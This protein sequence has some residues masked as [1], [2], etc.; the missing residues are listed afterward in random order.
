MKLLKKISAFVLG[1]VLCVV[2]ASCGGK[3][4]PKSIDE[5]ATYV[6]QMYI[7]KAETAASFEVVDQVRVG[8]EIFS[9]SWSREITS[10]EEA[11]VTIG[12]A[13][14]HKV[15][16]TI[17]INKVNPVKTEYKVTAKIENA[18]KSESKDVEFNWF[19]PKYNKNT[20]A[21][22][23]AAQKDDP[24]M[25]SGIVTATT[26][27]STTYKNVGVWLQD[28]EGGYYAYQL[29]CESEEKFLAEL[30]PGCA[31]EVTGKA[32]PYNGWKEMASKCTYE[33]ISSGNPIP[34]FKDITEDLKTKSNSELEVYQ[35]SKTS[36]TG[37]VSRLYDADKYGMAGFYVKVDADSE[38]LI[39]LKHTEKGPLNGGAAAHD[40]IMNKVTVGATVTVKGIMV[41]FNNPQFHVIEEEDVIVGSVELT[42][43]QKAENAAKAAAE[44]I[45]ASYTLGTATEV[46]LPEE[47]GDATLAWSVVSG[48]DAAAISGTKLT[49]TPAAAEKT[50]EL[51]V[52]ATVNGQSYEH[53]ITT[54]VTLISEVTPIRELYDLAKD[55]EIHLIEGVIVG[56]DNYNQAYIKDS[57][58]VI[59]CR[60]EIAGTKIGDTVKVIVN[61]NI[62]YGFPRVGND[63]C[64]LVSKTEAPAGQDIATVRGPALNQT[65]AQFV[66]S[67]K[68]EGSTNSNPNAA[69]KYI[70]LTD[71]TLKKSGNYIN[72]YY[73]ESSRINCYMSTEFKTTYADLLPDTD[74]E[75]VSVNVYGYYVGNDTNGYAKFVPVHLLAK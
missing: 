57:T 73:G 58:G 7:N 26:A 50:V 47:Q 19:V 24:L 66:A 36:F 20:W 41:W 17:V 60:T 15:P 39:F 55:G 21:E 64:E 13:V 32:S 23:N 42:D 16:F 8:E 33:F 70:C 6:R 12:Q 11:A 25:I 31:I 9:V 71:V 5:A 29:K 38:Y 62:N 44:T 27:Y 61:Y 46:T 35:N 2:L 75:E 49:L 65:A 14:S 56:M 3:Q 1:L 51:K 68:V 34:D 37:T 43:A 67:S 48:S 59:Y 28:A 4:G 22:W 53:T 63:V 10:G 74:G 69:G 52:T 45:K 30:Q 18:D 72:A 40:A 54:K